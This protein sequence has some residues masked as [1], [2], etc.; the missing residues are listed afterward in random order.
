MFTAPSAFGVR[1]LITDSRYSEFQTP[2][3]HF[4]GRYRPA[5]DSYQA[6]MAEVSTHPNAVVVGDITAGDTPAD[7]PLVAYQASPTVEAAQ[8]EDKQ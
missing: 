2:C 8:W 7:V 5:H 4:L 1:E 6:F 3:Q